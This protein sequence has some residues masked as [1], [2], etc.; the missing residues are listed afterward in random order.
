MNSSSFFESLFSHQ[1]VKM[2][3]RIKSIKVKNPIIYTLVP[4]GK[5][6]N[7]IF[8]KSFSPNNLINI[9]LVQLYKRFLITTDVMLNTS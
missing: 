2:A 4:S 7:S 3:T 1:N 5:F 9:S 8:I 6:K